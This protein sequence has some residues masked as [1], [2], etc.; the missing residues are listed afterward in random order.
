MKK[1]ICISMICILM[2]GLL[3]ACGNSL[4]ADRST[5]YVQKK[6][7]VIGAAVGELDKDYYAEDG[8]ET[9]I[10]E[11]VEAYQEQYGK[12]SV[13]VNDFSVEDN[14][15]KL[16]IEYAGYQDYQELN[17]V[18]LFAGTIPQALAAGYSFDEEFTKVTDGSLGE[19]VDAE[20]VIGFDGKVVILSEKIDVK[21]DGTIKYVSS[22]YATIKAKDTVSLQLPEDAADGEN[23]KLVYI[24]Y[25]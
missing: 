21:V 2:T 3:T 17:N 8:L 1:I 4:E 7:T 13:K 10:N 6:G 23:L 20:E 12:K 24:V 14:I 15:A 11:K 5:V 9:Y 25:E 22:D 19:G 18:T 16:F